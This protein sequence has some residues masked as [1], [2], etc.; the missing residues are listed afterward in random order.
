MSAG[1]PV[2]VSDVGGLREAAAGYEGARLVPPQDPAALAAAL[3]AVTDQGAA[4]TL[5]S[6]PG[7]TFLTATSPC[8]TPPARATRP[9]QA[10]TWCDPVSHAPL[11]VLNEES[12]RPVDLQGRRVRPPATSDRRSARDAGT[13]RVAGPMRR[14]L[15]RAGLRG[16]RRPVGRTARTSPGQETGARTCQL[17]DLVTRQKGA[18]RGSGALNPRDRDSVV[19]LGQRRRAGGPNPPFGALMGPVGDDGYASCS[20]V[21]MKGRDCWGQTLSPGGCSTPA[22]NG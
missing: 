8:S 17:G 13:V 18:Y 11:H 21:P 22:H 16:S 1:L 15:R 7:M 2:I 20:G 12:S 4:A 3:V 10:I 5:M 14:A 6:A 19:R 9:A